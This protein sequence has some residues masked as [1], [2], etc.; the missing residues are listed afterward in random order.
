MILCPH[1][2]K[3]VSKY[4]I[5][6]H[7]RLK[8]T[9]E[10]QQLCKGRDTFG[11]SRAW[12]KGLTK[13]NDERVKKVS[14]SMSKVMIENNPFKGK[15]HDSSKKQ[16][17]SQSM[18][19]AHKEGR[20]NNWQDSKKYDNSSFPEKFFEQVIENEFNNKNCVREHR[21]GPFSLDFAW[22]DKKKV[23][24]IDGSQHE[25]PEQKERDQR[26][27]ESLFQNGWQ[28]L[29]IKWNEMFHNPRVYIDKALQFIES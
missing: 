2:N 12:N 13:D 17:I 26:K 28:I 15:S 9:E 29:R 18:K 25:Y 19:L 8:H 22:I 20:A 27:D 14:E 5:K 4:G 10:G 3:E 7:I 24:E 16:Q 21:F 23:I 6:N 11:S 1:C